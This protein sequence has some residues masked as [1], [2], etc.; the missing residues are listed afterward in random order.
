M[1]VK[2]ELFE[3]SKVSEIPDANIFETPSDKA[4]SFENNDAGDITAVAV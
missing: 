4:I 2:G 1:S 3:K